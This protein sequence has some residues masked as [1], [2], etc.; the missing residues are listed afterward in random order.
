M[1]TFS[2]RFDESLDRPVG[3]WSRV[4]LVLFIF[5]FMPAFVAPLWR[6][7]MIAPQYPKGLTMDIY[8]NEL[9][10]GNEGKDIPEINQLN[11]YIGMKTI[12]RAEV[13]ELD[14]IP[15]VFGVL[16]LL[17]LRAATIGN[18]RSLIDVAVLNSFA[19][20]FV[21]G[22]FVYK[23]YYFGHNLDPTAPVNIEP[24]MPVI[25]GFKQIANFETYSYP[26]W[27]SACVAANMFCVIL[28]LLWHFRPALFGR[29]SE[30]K[31][32]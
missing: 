24:F 16:L 26:L 32:V 20:L 31:P 14:W 2:K 22:R 28:I 27:G 21:L 7:H 8:L 18:G 23:L 11:H 10:G 5:V 17:Q 9:V 6:I 19:Y 1:S 4:F 12:D 25:I 30:T 15:F 3:P 29:R 13:P